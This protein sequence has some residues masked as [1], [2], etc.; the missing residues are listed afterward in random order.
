MKLCYDLSHLFLR[1]AGFDCIFKIRCSR[2]FSVDRVLMAASIG[3]LDS[4]VDVFTDPSTFRLP[5]LDSSA[6]LVF[7]FRHDGAY[8][9]SSYSCASVYDPRF[10]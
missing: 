3:V 6:A 9:P 1:P 5:R 10:V 2:G 7:V 4:R 8:V